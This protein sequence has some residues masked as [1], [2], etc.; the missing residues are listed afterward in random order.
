M[1][2]T[3]MITLLSATA[4]TLFATSAE[5]KSFDEK[6]D[7]GVNFKSDEPTNPGDNKPYKD[8]LSLVW[9]PASF[10]F[11]EQKAVGNSATFSNTVTGKQYLIVNDD[12]KANSTPWKLSAK[13]SELKSADGSKT[14]ASKLT[15]NLGDMQSYTIGT[16]IGED[17][18]FVPNKPDASGALG[19][20]D[21]NAG[22]TLGDGKVKTMTLEAG[23][24][25]GSSILEKKVANDVKGGVATLITDTKLVVTDAKAD[26]AAG[27]SFTGYVTW[28]MDDLQP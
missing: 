4:L 8:N 1:K 16:T 24:T 25:T 12:R 14:L 9:K 21:P 22:I 6:T 20:L 19:T 10:Q 5:A 15:F 28:T 23:S 7:V 3:L 27:E 2:K 13:L 18:D 11:G 17:N 26:Q